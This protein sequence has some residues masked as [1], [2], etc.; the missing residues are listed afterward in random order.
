MLI[1]SSGSSQPSTEKIARVIG[2]LD[3]S[4]S[5]LKVFKLLLFIL[6]ELV[7]MCAERAFF[8]C[9]RSAFEVLLEITKDKVIV[10]IANGAFLNVLICRVKG[11]REKAIIVDIQALVK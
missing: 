5:T 8:T 11:N 4:Y 7:K 10:Q 3:V 6:P 9:L 1:W 2:W